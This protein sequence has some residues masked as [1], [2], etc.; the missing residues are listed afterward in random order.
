[1]SYLVIEDFRLGM[2][3][4]KKR[5][6]GTAGAL[7]DGI[8]GHITRGGDFERRKKF[9]EKYVLPVGTFGLTQINRRLYVFGSA[10]AP[11]G[12]SPSI[13]YQQ[14]AHTSTANMT[15][16]LDV[17]RFNSKIYVVAEFDN[18]DVYHY[19]D[20][21]RVTDWD[22]VAGAI[23]SND[24]VAARLAAKI[25]LDSRYIASAV[26][27]QVIIEAAVAN[28]PFS[29]SQAVVNGGATNDQTITLTLIQVSDTT[30]TQIYTADIGGTAEAGDGFTITIDGISYVTT[31]LGSAMGLTAL[32]YQSKLYSVTTSLMEFSAVDDPTSVSSGTGSGFINMTNQNE[33]NEALV[34]TQIY[35]NRMAIFSSDNIQIWLIAVDPTNNAFQQNLQNTGALS[36]RSILQ[37]GNIDVFYLSESGIRSI[38]ARDASN[39]PAVNDVGV[40]IDSFVQEYIA[41]LSG[42]QIARACALIE[43]LTGRYW[44]ALHNIIIVYSYFPGSK[45]TAWTYYDLTDEI[46]DNDISE[47]VKV[48]NRVYIRSG[49]SV[50]L[51]GG[52]TNA[53]YPD[54]GE[55]ITTVG[56]PYLS[57]DKPGTI[58][59]IKSFD[60]AIT[61]T[62]QV[63]LMP[64]AADDT[65]KLNVGTFT[66]TTFSPFTNNPIQQPLAF[67]AGEMIC[68]SA[69]PA[70]I[71][72]MVLHFDMEGET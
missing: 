67:F 51:Y 37:Y 36:A 72:K 38:K 11:G 25:S 39:A 2:D 48:G 46:G 34:G 56:I 64:N 70:S 63:N 8:N 12:M 47:M 9:V 24:S 1:M 41:E 29:I 23:M 32:T 14:L 44:L 65:I 18:G 30:T 20:G 69:G 33:D 52:D 13:T 17:T 57:A 26:G 60:A 15:N 6:S 50:F 35:Q 42:S 58:K 3:R 21:T 31:M 19:Y 16:V 7:W 45:I 4:R 22:V 5:I 55:C 71:S 53:V 10:G 40:A 49:D 54:A 68:S 62:W 28:V 59:G 61:N 27:S 66:K 43:P